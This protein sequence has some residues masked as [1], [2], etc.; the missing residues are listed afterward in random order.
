MPG[1]LRLLSLRNLH[2]RVDPVLSPCRHHGVLSSAADGD[3]G[4]GP[5]V[6][7]VSERDHDP[8]STRRLVARPGRRGLNAGIDGVEGRWSSVVLDGTLGR[9]VGLR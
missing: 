5:G 4:I 6:P 7:P 1:I 8:V 3:A 2:D 9:M